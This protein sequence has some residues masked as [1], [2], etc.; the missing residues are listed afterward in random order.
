VFYGSYNGKDWSL[1][2]AAEVSIKRHV[3]VRGAANP[4][5]PTWEVYFEHRLG[6]KMAD[7]LRGRRQLIRLWREQDGLCPVC[8]QKI[9]QLTG[10][11]NHH[12]IGRSLGG[13]DKAENRVLLHPNCHQQVHNQGLFVEKPRPSPGV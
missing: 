9:T 10:W 1:S 11:H 7:D 12:L 4:Y 13:S 8:Q 2:R 6:V 5:D 3:K